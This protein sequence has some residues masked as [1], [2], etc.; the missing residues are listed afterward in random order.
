M[1]LVKGPEE[2][3]G[4]QLQ[5]GSLVGRCPGRGC[6]K[7][8][9]FFFFFFSEATCAECGKAGWKRRHEGPQ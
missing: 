5:F 3:K 2:G 6:L 8:L 1:A 4:V 7:I 9:F